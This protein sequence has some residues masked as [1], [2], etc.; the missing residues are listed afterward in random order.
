[1]EPAYWSALDFIA[2]RR[3][4]SINQLVKEVAEHVD[5]GMSLPAALRMYAVNS[6]RNK[7]I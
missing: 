5:G 4:V 3:G 6:L 2:D 1:M 7:I